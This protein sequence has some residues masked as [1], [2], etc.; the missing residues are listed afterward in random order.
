MGIAV[1]MATNMPPHN[2]TEVI[3]ACLM[4]VKNPDAT[5]ED[6]MEHIK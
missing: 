4:L 2:L 3:D 1:G 5:I 6:I